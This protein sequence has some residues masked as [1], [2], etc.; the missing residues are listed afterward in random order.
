MN[1]QKEVGLVATLPSKGLEKDYEVPLWK[2]VKEMRAA[3]QNRTQACASTQR[4]VRPCSNMLMFL[5]EKKL[6]PT[7]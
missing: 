3:S 7:A 1:S 6:S 4:G 2:C 5:A